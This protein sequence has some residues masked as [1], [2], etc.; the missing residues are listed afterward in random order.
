MIYQ[1]SVS[2]HKMS[3]LLQYL[4]DS[5][6]KGR[7][8]GEVYKA[9]NPPFEYEVFLGSKELKLWDDIEPELLSRGKKMIYAY[10]FDPPKKVKTWY[11]D[12]GQI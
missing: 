2:F 12:L 11:N 8:L 5:L 7:E 1:I 6:P 9:I 10:V 4:D 3:W